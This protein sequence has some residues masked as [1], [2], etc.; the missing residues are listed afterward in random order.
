MKLTNDIKA[1]AVNARS[2]TK[3]KHNPN[4]NIE[5]NQIKSNKPLKM[6]E[7]FTDFYYDYNTTDLLRANT[8]FSF[9]LFILHLMSIFTF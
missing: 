1:V 3:T 9:L 2:Q 5:S 4:S 6:Q 7:T 8:L